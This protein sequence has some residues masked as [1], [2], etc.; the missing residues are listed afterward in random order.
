MEFN[1]LNFCEVFDYD[2]AFAQVFARCFMQCSLQVATNKFGKP[3]KDTAFK[4]M[5]QLHDR[6]AFNPL[7]VVNMT[8]EERQKALES[9][10]F[11]KEK[12][13]ETLKG[14]VCAGGRK[15][16]EFTKPDDAAS[17]MALL[18]PIVLA[19]IIDAKEE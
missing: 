14:R 17:P 2:E 8:L 13:N 12:H 19:A 16:H 4:E 5:K 7:D 10:I 3:A 6:I 1:N 9:L 15:Q 18:E 11:V